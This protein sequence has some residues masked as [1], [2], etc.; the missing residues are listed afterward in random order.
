MTHKR[1][2]YYPDTK[3]PA[4]ITGADQLLIEIGCDQVVLLVKGQLP[5]QPEAFEVFETDTFKHKWADVLAG[6]KKGSQLLGRTYQ[7]VD[8]HYNLPDALLVPGS[9]F[10]P[11][12]G[13]DYLDQ[14]YGDNSGDPTGYESL[15]STDII[16]SYRIKK[17]VSEW[18]QRE[19]PS[20]KPSH[21]YTGMLDELLSRKL[22]SDNFVAIRFYTKHM[23]IA[24]LKNKALQLVQ[25]FNYEVEEDI[26][27]YLLSII[28][29]FELDPALTHAEI[30]G[31]LDKRS[32]IAL[33]L[34]NLFNNI[35]WDE[36]GNTGIFLKVSA[37]HPAHYFTAYYKM[38]V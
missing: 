31:Q 6:I 16:V 1:I 27:Y 5:K 32:G 12:S 28:Q 17:A 2:G 19:F 25:S 26:L 34:P 21:I 24:V 20:H 14:I 11:E 37:D 13:R 7:R 23:V 30:T 38:G 8:V 4:S 22:P 9:K 33:Q 10:T 15:L 36:S 18:V 35:K 3:A 29:Q